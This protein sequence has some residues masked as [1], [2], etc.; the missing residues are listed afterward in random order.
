VTPIFILQDFSALSTGELYALLA[1]RQQVFVV[2]QRCPYAD[3]DGL[4]P[5]AAHLFCVDGD[6]APAAVPHVVACAR[7]FA[8][9]V[10]GDAAVIGRVATASSVRRTGLGRALMARAIEAIE[11]RHGSVDIRLG[12]QAYL[13]R[14]YGSFGFVRAGADYLEDDIPHLPMIRVSRRRDA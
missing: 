11:R 6:A 13:E 7:L 10:R 3:A 12:A 4:D 9:G 5:V 2:E 14:F 1:L 8:P